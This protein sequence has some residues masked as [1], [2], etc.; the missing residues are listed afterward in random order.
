MSATLANSLPIILSRLPPILAS[1]KAL[2]RLQRAASSL[3]P[4]PRGGV[5]SRLAADDPQ[6]DLQQCIRMTEGEAR[7]LIEHLRELEAKTDGST[8][9]AWQRIVRFYTEWAN[10]LTRLHKGI[11]EIW[12]EIDLEP[13]EPLSSDVALP[14]LFFALPHESLLSSHERIAII[15]EALERLFDSSELKKKILERLKW[16]VDACPDGAFIS[17]IGVMLSRPGQAFRVNVKRLLPHHLDS[18]L[19]Q[20][21]YP[22]QVAPLHELMTTLA[23]FVDRITLCLDVGEQVQAKVGLECMVDGPLEGWSDLLDYLVEQGL[24]QKEKRDGLLA[25]PSDISPNMVATE[26]PAD[27]LH[28]SL[29][30]PID[31]FTVFECQL[32]HIKIV[33]TPQQS[34]VAK[35]YLWFSHQWRKPR[36][37]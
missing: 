36:K 14:S 33:Y 30:R 35:G 18:Y 2:T 9:S 37:S 7:L 29:L 31:H 23:N 34:L 19:Q 26:W 3:P 22:G 4:I 5:E 8:R 27:L 17:H 24:C 21:G 12:L 16:S 20:V 1:P 15:V 13:L 11:P 32:S 6:V 25:W 10:P 28:A